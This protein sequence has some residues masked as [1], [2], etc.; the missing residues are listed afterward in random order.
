MDQDLIVFIIGEATM[1]LMLPSRPAIHSDEYRT[2]ADY[3]LLPGGAAVNTATALTFL[4]ARVSICSHVGDDF[5]GEFLLR[6]LSAHNICPANFIRDP[7][8]KTAL[9]IIHVEENGE[10]GIFQHKGGNA[11]LHMKDAAWPEILSASIVHIAGAF[12][13]EC[14]DGPPMAQFLK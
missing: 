4:G 7:N 12:T 2:F 14:F 5:P 11:R 9:S 6:W 1:D 8:A 3:R 13:M 10:L